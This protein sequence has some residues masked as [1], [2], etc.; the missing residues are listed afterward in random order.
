MADPL[1][2]DGTQTAL[3]HGLVRDAEAKAARSLDEEL[4]S[5][6]V[7][8]LM[9]HQEDA[10]LGRST[11][12]LAWLESLLGQGRQREQG[13]RDVG[14]Q[15]LLIAGLFPE[16]ADRRRVPLSY[17]QDLGQDAYS[18]LGARALGGLAQLYRH[19][20]SAFAE[21]VRV[22]FELRRLA[23][24]AIALDPALA[25]GWCESRGRIVPE[26]AAEMFPG[27]V[28]LAGPGTRQ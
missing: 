14:D 23:S 2:V 13:L 6:L 1:L 24:D 25:Y 16:L 9:R 19:L 11:V 20:A 10:S 5:Y 4:E 28:V 18:H 21:L 17:F 3:W 8:T 27:A 7:F 12:A 22:L 15:C 26:R